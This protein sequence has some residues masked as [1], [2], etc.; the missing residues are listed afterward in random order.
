MKECPEKLGEWIK[1]GFRVGVSTNVIGLV[2]VLT[3]LQNSFYSCIYYQVLLEITIHQH[4]RKRS[5][6][7]SSPSEPSTTV[8]TQQRKA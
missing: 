2:K 1:E 8:S 4:Q 3:N 5:D 7:N 6:S